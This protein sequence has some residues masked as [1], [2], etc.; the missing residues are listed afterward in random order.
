M[1]IRVN[2]TS[3]EVKCNLTILQFLE[4]HLPDQTLTGVAIALNNRVIPK[5]NWTNQLLQ[6]DDKLTIITATQGG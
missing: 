6:D 3:F 2:K 5:D 4:Q 1:T